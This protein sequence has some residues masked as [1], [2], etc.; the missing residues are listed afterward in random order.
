M[1]PNLKRKRSPDLN[2]LE[3]PQPKHPYLSGNFAPIQQTLH[4][5]PCTYTGKI[6]NEL[7]AGEYVRN[8]SNPVSNDDLGRDAHWFDGDGMLSGVSF[9]KDAESGSITPEFVNQF[10]LTDLYLKH[11]LESAIDKADLAFDSDAGG[12]SGKHYIRHAE[13]TEDGGIG[14]T[15]P[16]VRVEAKDQEDQRGEYEC[17]V[18]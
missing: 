12:P 15:I 3:T 4:L 8:G 13:D 6:P 17:G 10:I 5:T 1:P 9:R 14:H 7:A 11:A 16:S 18:S 2:I